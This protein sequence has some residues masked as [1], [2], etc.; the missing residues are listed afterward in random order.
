M[1][2]E[3]SLL[4]I[5]LSLYREP[6]KYLYSSSFENIYFILLQILSNKSRWL[7]FLSFL[8]KQLYH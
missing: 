3:Y 6:L 5:Q 1:Y 2:G 4:W 8:I 7:K